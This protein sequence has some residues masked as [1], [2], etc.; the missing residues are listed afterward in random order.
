M[1]VIE[2]APEIQED[3]ERIIDHLLKH[4]SENT[5][6][7]IDAIISALDLLESSP[8]IGRPCNGEL[9]ELII[10]RGAAGYVAL[11]QYIEEIDIVFVLAIRSHREAGYTRDADDQI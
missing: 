7:R 8:M 11:Y 5:E 2:L 3:F 1:A 4:E 6:Q 9:R 10:G